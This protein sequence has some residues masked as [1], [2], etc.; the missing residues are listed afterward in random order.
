VIMSRPAHLQMRQN[1]AGTDGAPLSPAQRFKAERGRNDLGL[2]S[3]G[4]ELSSADIIDAMINEE[5]EPDISDLMSPSSRP[6]VRQRIQEATVTGHL[7]LSNLG[8]SRMPTDSYTIPNLEKITSCD[9]SANDL[10]AIP[11]ALK[12]LK[13]LEKLDLSDND[14]TEVPDW[15]R[16]FKN[17]RELNLNMNHL[18]FLP[19]AIADCR[20][21]LLIRIFEFG[22]NNDSD[23]M[24]PADIVNGGVPTI[25][26]F[27]KGM[28]S[29]KDMTGRGL[30]AVGWKA[31]PPGSP[32]P[33]GRHRLGEMGENECVIA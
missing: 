22:G 17:L 28:A 11:A 5:E 32:P 31:P 2:F 12:K 10:P 8:L 14:L 13:G 24:P 20:E 15:I 23:F 16:E 30:Q 7:D 1:P 4:A 9:L 21:D 19:P 33:A 26:S 27:Y 29:K 25:K 6:E 3:P 18:Y